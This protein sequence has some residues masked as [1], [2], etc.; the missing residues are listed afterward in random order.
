MRKEL[1]WVEIRDARLR[2]DYKR[3]LDLTEGNDL[4]AI[5]K[6]EGDPP[7]VYSM[8]FNCRG[9]VGV[10]ASGPDF[11]ELHRVRISLPVDYPT[12]APQLRWLTPIF[13]PNISAEGTFVC[14]DTW[15]PSRFLDD[16]C[17][18]LG[19][20]IQYKNFNPL[21]PLRLDAAAWSTVNANILPVDR[22]PLRRGS[23]A[24][25]EPIEFDIRIL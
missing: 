2:S 12:R 17:I 7:E 19:R 22:R 14:V 5:E 13:H 20:M 11:G 8:R 16:L 18:I 15:Y 21:N 10:S 4:I 25:A 9:V 24:P 6:T 23:A 1:T 3:M